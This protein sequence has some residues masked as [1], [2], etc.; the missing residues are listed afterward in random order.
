[1]ISPNT[2]LQGR[3]RIIRE[4]GSGGMGTVYEAIDQHVNCIVALK[5]TTTDSYTYEA[6]E[7]EAALLANLHHQSLPNVMDFFSEEGSNFLVMEFVPGHDLARLLTLR[8]TPFPQE[9]VVRW[10]YAIL[11]VL[12][13]LHSQ[14]PPVLHR[15]IKPSNLKVTERDE[16]F[17]LD[18][19]LAKG[20]IG[21]MPTLVT[22]RSIRGYTP[23][24]SSLEQI[25][26]HRTNARSDLY[27]LGATLYHLLAGVP[28][29]G[30]PTRFH[31]IE[32]EKPDPLQSIKSLN[33]KTSTNVVRVIL[34]SMATSP[35]DR[36]VS[37]IAMK[38]ALRKAVE[39]DGEAEAVDH[40]VK[41]E[42]IKPLDPRESLVAVV[43]KNSED[44]LRTGARAVLAANVNKS[45][46]ALKTAAT[47]A[48]RV[49][50][51]QQPQTSSYALRKRNRLGIALLIVIGSII[52]VASWLIHQTKG[53]R[54]VITSSPLASNTSPDNSPGILRSFEFLTMTLN[55]DG[56]VKSR[57]LKT[58]KEYSV[59][60]GS[61]IEM[62][63]VAIPP[64]EFTM[65]SP[66]DEE[67]RSSSEGP[68]HQVQISYWFFMG[69][70]EVTQAQWRALMGTNP[71]EFSGCDQCPVENVSWPEAQEFCREL[72]KRTG[73]LYRLPSEAEW[74]YAARAT[75]STPFAFG[76]TITPE[77]VN[78][79]G[80][81]PYGSAPI[82]PNRAKPIQVG[83]LKVANL[84]GLYD[85]HGNVRE[86]CQDR[87]RDDYSD[88]AGIFPS[89]GSAWE[90]GGE[91]RRVLRGGD[92][93]DAA[94]AVGSARREYSPV[95]FFSLNGGF[96]VVVR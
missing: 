60:L 48:L 83:S 2:I 16:I 3:Y 18:F 90:R 65:G 17:L 56:T 6:F 63:M 26:G 25:L 78:Y 47:L 42:E 28:P 24:Y 72:S 94:L 59:D 96:R 43:R 79:N 40:F 71:S 77:I 27:S 39:D 4:L 81:Q 8:R 14:S 85:M 35:K 51:S 30:A 31:A 66:E 89:D 21:Q 29:V 53:K 36:P 76:E 9:Q 58:A 74:E 44:S 73:R 11:D 38:Y 57:E 49:P 92:W 82:G 34:A 84:F 15:D 80:T 5:E 23:A 86:W 93:S 37:A 22:S 91:S 87:Y 50:H 19:G 20:S 75:T 61:G 45:E 95:L 70:F 54:P 68:Q 62:V 13:Y 1:M 33:Q 67:G 12:D 88:K 52:A 41:I 32:D 7:R 55:H 46:L 64:G 69:K 10:A